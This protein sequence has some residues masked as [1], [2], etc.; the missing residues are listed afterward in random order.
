MG[1]G[2]AGPS[3][4]NCGKRLRENSIFNHVSSGLY[5]HCLKKDFEIFVRI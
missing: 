5:I 2:K 1:E 3:P 4:Q